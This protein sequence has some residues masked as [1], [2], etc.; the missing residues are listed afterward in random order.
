M[1]DVGSGMWDCG[2]RLPD[3]VSRQ[4]FRMSDWG[5]RIW[6][7]EFEIWNLRFGIR[8]CGLRITITAKTPKTKKSKVGLVRFEIRM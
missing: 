1:E 4:G 5:F 2:F 7:L 6:N 3:C 8:T